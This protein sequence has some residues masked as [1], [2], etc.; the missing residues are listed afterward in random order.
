MT[1]V[2]STEGGVPAD[3]LQHARPALRP[4][5]RIGPEVTRGDARVHIVGDRDT[6]AYLKVGAREAFLMRRLDGQ[7]TLAEIGDEY[8][9]RFG[10][11][12]AAANWQQLLGM[13]AS[14][15]LIEPAGEQQLAEVRDRAEQARRGEGRSPLLWRMPIGGLAD[16][17]PAV[18]RR[19][20]WLLAPAVAV[21]LT[22]LGAL[23]S[24]Y[25]VSNFAQL[26]DAVGAAPS[27]WS[28]SVVTV[29]VT[30]LV[31]GCHEFGHG[32]ACHRYGGRPTQI[33]LM[34]RFPLIA[35]YCK[36]DD[37]VT[38]E[39]RSHRVTT[40]F[41]GIYVNLIALLPFAALWWWGPASG[42]WHGLAGALLIVGTASTVANLVP[43]FKLD[44]YHMLEHAT[45]TMNLQ[46]ESFR[47]VGRFVRG[48]PAGVSAYP[49]RARVIFGGYVLLAAAI[50][51]PAAVLLVRLWYLT[52]A[53]L[54]GTAGAVAFLLG[55]AILV[56]LFLWWAVSWRQR[57][58]KEA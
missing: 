5:V 7:H 40:S 51:V 4:A 46:S 52:L 39:R 55:E 43:V 49:T 35:P 28:V 19:V 57:R 42:W 3:W 54:W 32:I 9:H 10:K 33:G 15:A 29:V 31:I 16:R 38:F 41:A 25:V 50:L 24:L 12:L 11:R 23:I 14:R 21:P 1:T 47:F 26:Y 8:A 18:S 53:D 6:Q 36:V 45:A 34:W 2:D 37:V 58:R 48:G 44:G 20:G 56:A 17:V 22:V 27:R 30:W 13:L